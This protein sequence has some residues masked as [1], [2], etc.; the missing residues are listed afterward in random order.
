MGEM[1]WNLNDKEGTFN[2][3]T[4]RIYKDG[5]LFGY[6]TFFFCSSSNNQLRPLIKTI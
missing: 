4:G 2:K 1:R 5:N 3:E 6:T